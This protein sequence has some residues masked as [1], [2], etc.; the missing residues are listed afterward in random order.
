MTYGGRNNAQLLQHDRIGP[1]SMRRFTGSYDLL[2]QPGLYRGRCADQIGV[3]RFK[4]RRRR[5]LSSRKSTS[6]AS[7]IG[8]R[9]KLFVGATRAMMKLVLVISE[10]SAA[11]LRAQSPG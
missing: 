1:H 10:R 4:G 3:C 9:R 11:V 5:P 8:A 2:R 7:M 6:T